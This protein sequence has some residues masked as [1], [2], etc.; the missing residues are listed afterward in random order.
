MNGTKGEELSLSVSYTVQFYHLAFL[1]GGLLGPPGPPGGVA[2]A[3]FGYSEGLFSLY[4][5]QKGSSGPGSESGIFVGGM[6]DGF[7]FGAGGAIAI[8]GQVLLADCI[9]PLLEMPCTANPTD[10]YLFKS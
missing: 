7:V 8:Y 3:S 9:G 1:P 4:G 6:V 5:F 2:G 10:L